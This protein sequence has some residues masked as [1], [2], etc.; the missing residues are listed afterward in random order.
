MFIAV[1]VLSPVNIHKFM[2]DSLKVFNVLKI[3]SYNS[4]STAETHA[5]VRLFSISVAN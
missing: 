5:Y 4:S 1:N 3:S 2:P